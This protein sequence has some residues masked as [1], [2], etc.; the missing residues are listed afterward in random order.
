MNHAII[1][2][3]RSGSLERTAGGH[4]IATYLRSHDWDV[5]VIDF[6]IWWS[7]E[8]LQELVKS[9]ITDSTVFIG[10]STFFNHWPKRLN[11]FTKWLTVNYPKV[12]KVI[13]GQSVS[14]TPAHNID[15]WIDSFGELAILELAKY[16][17]GN[18]TS[19]PIFDYRQFGVKKL[20]LANKHYPSY[21]LPTYRILYEPRDFIDYREQLIIESGRGCKFSCE[22]CNFPVLGVKEDNSRSKDDFKEEIV[23]NYN[24]YG[25]KNYSLGDETFNDRIEKIIK[26]SEVVDTLNFKPWFNAFVRADLMVSHEKYW[27]NY[28]RLG[29]GGHYYGIETFHHAAGKAIGKGM[30]PNKLKAGILR[31]KSL[32][33]KNNIYRATISLICGLPKEPESSWHESVKWLEDNWQGQ[34]VF[35]WPLEIPEYND[36]TP[37]NLSKF[38]LNLEKY[39]L[40]RASKSNY[41]YKRRLTVCKDEVFWE[42]DLMDQPRA[43]ELTRD[44]NEKTFWYN[45]FKMA[46]WHMGD[47]MIEHNTNNIEDVLQYD[48]SNPEGPEAQT[49]IKDYIFKKLNW[50]PK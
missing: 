35:V 2:S 30:D 5:E 16:L 38:S 49:F 13:G 21:Q 31:F 14:L 36:T 4:R 33:E 6:A 18:S 12:S 23:F 40:R 28:I 15:Y 8:E 7:N 27:D 50:R 42:H 11:E 19:P 34:S 20:I 9:R 43:V 22:F 41:S 10:F 1:F 44:F 3:I 46:G 24:E 47:L 37:T 32:A 45:K 17:T 29:L 39:G 26:Y 25:V 48:V